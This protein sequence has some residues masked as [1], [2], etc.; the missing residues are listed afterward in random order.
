[1]QRPGLV[2]V[3]AALFGTALVG[4]CKRQPGPNEPQL[5]LPTKTK[6]QASLLFVGDLSVARGIAEAIDTDGKGDHAWP[7]EKMKPVFDAHDLVFGNLECAVTDSTA[8]EAVSKTYRIRAETKYLDRLHD[9]GVDVVSVANNHAMDFGLQGFES[10][11]KTLENEGVLAVG[12]QRREGFDHD[13]VIVDVG[14][15]KVGFLAYNEHGDE[16]KHDDWRPTAMRYRIGDVVDD[17]KAARP[18]VDFLIVSVHGGLELSHETDDWQV[19]DAHKVID[20]GADLWVGHHPHVVQ[21]WELYKGK[22]IAYSLGDFLFDKSSPWLVDRNRPRLFLEMNLR[23]DASGTVTAV[24][25]FFTGDQEAKTFRP[26]VSDAFVD[27]ASFEEPKKDAP[28]TFRDRLKDAQV[29]RV[30]KDARGADVVTVCDRWEKR[31]AT[32]N[33][34]AWRW[35]APRWGCGKDN[36]DDGKRGWESVAATAEMFGPTLKR[37]IWAHPHAGGPLRMRFSSVTLGLQLTGFAGVPNWGVTLSGQNEA[38]GKPKTPP[39]QLQVTVLV[40]DKP[41]AAATLSV[42]CETGTLPI[43]IDTAK[44]KGEDAVVVV[45]VSGGS[46]DVEGRFVYDLQV[47][48]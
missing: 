28:T 42:P 31:R 41:V 38:K 8:E 35:L 25:R 5:T 10:T 7:F 2:V 23:R 16:Y 21:P 36:K 4:A 15:F 40:G 9:V 34:H 29:E 44:N 22:L 13:V 20:A 45:E 24:H 46:G 39:V 3:I 6:D 19:S 27:V 32:V 17:V 26:F 14:G 11:L 43:A 33:G 12:A 48:P 1:M 30:R 37:G 18:K 47:M